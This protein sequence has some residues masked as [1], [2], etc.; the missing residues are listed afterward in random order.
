MKS[1]KEYSDEQIFG[2]KNSKNVPAKNF[3]TKNVPTK[4]PP[5]MNSPGTI[6][7]ETSQSIHPVKAFF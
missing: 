1:D 3:A 2:A 6:L 5:A 7:Y 4:N